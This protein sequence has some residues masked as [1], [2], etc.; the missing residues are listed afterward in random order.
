MRFICILSKIV[1]PVGTNIR[2]QLEAKNEDLNK[3]KVKGILKEAEELW[4]SK[5]SG[6]KKFNWVQKSS[7]PYRPVSFFLVARRSGTDKLTNH[8]PTN[9]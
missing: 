1:L 2:N 7:C 9:E 5:S 8:Q 6:Y 3:Q 4:E